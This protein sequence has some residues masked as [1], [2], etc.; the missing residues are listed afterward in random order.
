MK[1]IIK[2]FAFPALVL[3]L[4]TILIKILDIYLLYPWFDIPMHFVGGLAVSTSY[5]LLLK[6]A[7]KK[8]YLGKMHETAFFA[9]VIALV[10]LTAVL[11]EFAEFIADAVIQINS[12]LSLADTM[13]DLFLGLVG[14]VVG[15]FAMFL[16]RKPKQ[17]Q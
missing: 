9:F 6:H 4:H 1:T 16:S 8:N 5:F 10:G 7:Q 12:Q 17:L 13:A 3:A 14:G 11:W 2:I 15:F